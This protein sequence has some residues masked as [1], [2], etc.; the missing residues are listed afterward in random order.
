MI[1]A[2]PSLAGAVAVA[3]PRAAWPVP[4]SEYPRVQRLSVARVGL[5]R[6]EGIADA[7][8][9]LGALESSLEMR[10]IVQAVLRPVVDDLEDARCVRRRA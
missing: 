10:L 4:A 9:V 1:A 2:W 3:D 6:L 7:L 5:A 8:A